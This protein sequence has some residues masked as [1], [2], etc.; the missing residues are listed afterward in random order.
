MRAAKSTPLRRVWSCDASSCAE[1]WLARGLLSSRLLCNIKLKVYIYLLRVFPYLTIYTIR[2]IC[3][4][5]FI[6]RSVHFARISAESVFVVVVVVRNV[7]SKCARFVESLCRYFAEPRN[8]SIYLY[9][10][11]YV[12]ARACFHVCIY[13]ADDQLIGRKRI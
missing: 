9:I 7:A 8:M 11:I 2:L 3:N 6:A 12:F 4:F 5:S 13:C 10:R 1:A